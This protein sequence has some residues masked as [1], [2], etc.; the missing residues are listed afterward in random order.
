VR[1]I[2]KWRGYTVRQVATV[3][4]QLCVSSTGLMEC[5]LAGGGLL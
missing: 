2:E 1:G 5:Y 4:F 3:R